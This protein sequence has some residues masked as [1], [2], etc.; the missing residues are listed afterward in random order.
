M[1][2]LDDIINE[3]LAQ[4]EVGQKHRTKKITTFYVPYRKSRFSDVKTF[5][6]YIRLFIMTAAILCAMFKSVQR[7]TTCHPSEGS[8]IN[9]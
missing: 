5:I 7:G 2:P 4:S 6:R 8:G 3:S 9:I 1:K